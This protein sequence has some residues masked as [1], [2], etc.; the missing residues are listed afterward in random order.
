[1]VR[2]GKVNFIVSLFIWNFGTVYGVSGNEMDKKPTAF[3]FDLYESNFLKQMKESLHW[4]VA[5]VEPLK[6][7]LQRKIMNQKQYHIPRG[8]GELVP[9]SRT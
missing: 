2:T 4:I 7:L 9:P 1:M 6:L 5:K 8:S 3:L